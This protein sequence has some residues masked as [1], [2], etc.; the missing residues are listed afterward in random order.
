MTNS[1][2]QHQATTNQYQYQYV[3]LTM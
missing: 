3:A 1:N 2:A